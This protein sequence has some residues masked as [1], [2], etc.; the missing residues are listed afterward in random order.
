MPRDDAG[1]R[2]YIPELD[3]LRFCA[4]LAVFLS[5]AYYLE[6]PSRAGGVRWNSLDWW[7]SSA[8]LAGGF[9]V[10]LFF[11]LSSFLITS[12]LV[13]ETERR[14]RIDVP[15]FWLRRILRI[16]PLY[17]FF[18]LLCWVFADLPLRIVGAFV[19]FS[20]NW[21][22]LAWPVPSIVV[23]LW[24]VSVEEQFYLVWPLLLAVLPGKCLRRVCLGMIVVSLVARSAMLASGSGLER[25]WLNTLARLDPIAVGALIALSW[26]GRR[27]QLG[28]IGQWVLGVGAPVLVVASTGLIWHELLQ[29]S[30]QAGPLIV[31][32]GWFPFAAAVLVFLVIALA[33]GGM[34]LAALAGRGAW[35]RHP[36]LVYLGRISYGLYVFHLGS[37]KLAGSLWWPW[38]CLL[39]FGIT[40]LVASLSYRLIERPFLR[41]KER[42]AYIPS[43]PLATQDTKPAPA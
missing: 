27:A 25:T 23:P 39:G 26:S 4:F 24:S 29:P 6:P 37:I 28:R 2:F 33:C 15:A 21:A 34:V 10:D 30:V 36:V 32:T 38:R 19:L 20:G 16:W 7:T 42:F 5:H 17:Y 14:G 9:G 18:I 31:R 22:M 41:M 8:F 12:L 40:V 11:V 13:R 3:G 43:A 35:L 1:D